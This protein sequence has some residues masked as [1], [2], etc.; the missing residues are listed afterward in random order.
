MREYSAY[1]GLIIIIAFAAICE[2]VSSQWLMFDRQQIE[3]GQLWRL[4][5]AHFVHLSPT[6]ALGNGL[7]VLMLGY[8]AGR[9]L[10]NAMGLVLFAW[11]TA[12]VGIGLY[13]YAGYLQRYVGLSGVLHGLLI[14]APFVSVYYGRGI[15]WAF[16]AVIVAKVTWEQTSYYDAMALAETIGG[17]VEV[18]SHLLGCVAG[19]LFLIG[20][21]LLRPQYLS[22]EVISKEQS[23]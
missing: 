14:V 9:Y 10:N 18:N 15:A 8:I 4:F 20:L 13:F 2:P 22:P 21:R 12:W 19:I 23:E 5:S 16:F 17:R 6:H 7:G 11:C 1:I 3:Q